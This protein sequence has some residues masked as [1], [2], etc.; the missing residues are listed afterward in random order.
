MT[1]S[2]MYQDRPWL[3]KYDADVKENLSYEARCMPEFLKQTSAR[4]PDRMALLFQGYKIT[5]RK[6]DQMV[7]Q[8]TSALSNA[9]IKKGDS[10]AILLPNLIP[11]VAAYYAVLKIGA[12]GVMNNPLYSDREL[13]HQLYDSQS[14]MLFTLDLLVKRMVALRS[15]TRVKQIIYTSIGDYLPFPKNVLFPLMAPK[16]GLSAKVTPAPDVHPWK[17]FL[18]S[19]TEPPPKVTPAF[20]DTAMFQYT[21]GTTG[22][23][24]G[25]ILTHSN[26]SKQV[27]QISAWFPAFNSDEIMLGA[28]PFFHVFGL[29]CSM[30]L[31]IH[32]GWGNILVPKPQPPYLLE[33]IHK[34]RP[35]F[36]PLVPTMYIGMLNHPAIN[37]ADLTSIKGC[38]SGSAPL[39]REVIKA[40]EAKTGATI[41]EGYGL[42][43][44]CPVTH[45]NPF[46][47]GRKIGSIG[48]PISDTKARIVDLI[49]GTIDMP[50][51]K[52]GE[53]LVKGPQVMQGYLQQ[54]QATAQTLTSDGWLHTGDIAKMD[55]EGYFYIVDRKKDMIISGGFNVYPR[56]IE[57]VFFGHPKVKEACAIGIPHP[58]RGEA[59]KVFAVLKEDQ[60]AT[61]AE[62]LEY[63]QDKLAKYKWPVEIEFRQELP[64][65]SVGKLLKK[66]LRAEITKK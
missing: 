2:R 44:S 48:L 61:Q 54:P 6:L 34:F 62:L 40:F 13:E 47:G 55:E 26:L 43:E 46:K 21:G 8:C 5:Y 10:V 15:K 39:P 4:F 23:S 12:I 11:C 7:D 33:A 29:S 27:Q 36:A 3:T 18:K 38:F 63:C 45:I 65:S 31:A 25:V 16:K 9:G 66:D 42:T 24:K 58:K 19:G 56:D 49:D 50:M 35:T 14:V 17:A 41:V 57:E 30:N 59:V 60:T 20:E 1:T 51:G 52:P 22:V 64:K 32:R 28:L 37:K 53:L